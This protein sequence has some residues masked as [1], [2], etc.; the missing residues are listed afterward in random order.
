MSG[1]KTGLGWRGAREPSGRFALHILIASRRSFTRKRHSLSLAQMR[2][3]PSHVAEHSAEFH[4]SGPERACVMHLVA[5]GLS[6]PQL[7]R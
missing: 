7:P 1:R 6:R 3:C 5:Q 4:D 2:V